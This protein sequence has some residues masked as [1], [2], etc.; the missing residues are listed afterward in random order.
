MKGE[1]RNEEY[2]FVLNSFFFHTDSGLSPKVIKYIMSKR[3]LSYIVGG[4]DFQ[5]PCFLLSFLSTIKLIKT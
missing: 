4:L 2:M 1:R 3:F 5:V